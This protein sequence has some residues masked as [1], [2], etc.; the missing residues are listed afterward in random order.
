MKYTPVPLLVLLAILSAAFSLVPS[1]RGAQGVVHTLLST[2]LG[3]ALLHLQALAGAAML[4]T[5]SPAH[6]SIA[7]ILFL[8]F[9]LASLG[10]TL[11]LVL[12]RRR[13]PQPSHGSNAVTI[14]L[15]PSPAS[16]RTSFPDHERDRTNSIEKPPP[17]FLRSL[18]ST[19]NPFSSP[20]RC[21]PSSSFSSPS[22]SLPSLPPQR[23]L[24]PLLVLLAA[25]VTY[26]L[27]SGFTLPAT[28]APAPAPLLASLLTLPSPPAHLSL[29]L[30]FRVLETVFTIMSL[31]LVLL[32]YYLR[33]RTQ[34]PSSDAEHGSTIV[35]ARPEIPRRSMTRILS[36]P[37]TPEPRRVHS[38]VL[39]P[40]SPTSISLSCAS[41]RSA[42]SKHTHKRVPP[43]ASS[44]FFSPG[45]KRTPL[46]TPISLSLAPAPAPAPT[47]TTDPDPDPDPDPQSPT[48]TDTTCVPAPSSSAHTQE[49]DAR[50]SEETCPELDLPPGT[51]MSPSPARHAVLVSSPPTPPTAPHRAWSWAPFPDPLHSSSGPFLPPLRYGNGSPRT[52]RVY[53]TVDVHR[54]ETRARTHEQKEGDGDPTDLHDPFS[55]HNTT[56]PSSFRFRA[57]SLASS[58][59]SSSNTCFERRSSYDSGEGQQTRMSQWGRLPLVQ[60]EAKQRELERGKGRGLRI[61]TACTSSDA[62]TQTPTRSPTVVHFNTFP[63]RHPRS[64]ASPTPTP[65][66]STS[67]SKRR[68]PTPTP[69]PSSPT[70][71]LKTRSRRLQ[72]T[73]QGT[74]GR[75]STM[76][77]GSGSGREDALLAQRLLVELGAG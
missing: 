58:T 3:G 1:T 64:P 21:T 16:S 50:S 69:T 38:I 26:A 45:P 72:K 39:L 47:F 76:G 48:D 53:S 8:A 40:S 46:P 23:R 20:R 74:V 54:C 75:E 52:A 29:P 65:T 30:V 42:K 67:S 4:L 6:A 44:S 34:A 13:I 60:A 22:L 31:L 70:T 71:E 2:T 28:H 9:A 32:A 56:A 24:P 37:T 35:S 7:P 61:D 11:V 18:T 51:R 55:S 17:A 41:P 27:A 57:D 12:F 63:S 33:S 10:P 43:S 77:S 5:F 68:P 49:K 14:T 73:S 62:Q 19:N 25:Q 59:Y 36:P 66:R 15:V